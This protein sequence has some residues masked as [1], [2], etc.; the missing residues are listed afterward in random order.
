M[1]GKAANMPNNAGSASRAAQNGG[2]RVLRNC[3]LLTLPVLALQLDILG[4]IK[5]GMDPTKNSARNSSREK[6]YKKE[7]A[8]STQAEPAHR[9]ESNEPMLITP[10]VRFVAREVQALLM[11]LDSSHALR[12]RFGN[13]LEQSLTQEIAAIIEKLGAGSVS[14]IEVQE[15]VLNRIIDMLTKLK[16]EPKPEEKTVRE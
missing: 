16:N 2:G 3:V 12:K 5:R 8:D 9:P 7:G 15:I 14:L 4:M 6:G 1:L 11:I 13:D 10:I